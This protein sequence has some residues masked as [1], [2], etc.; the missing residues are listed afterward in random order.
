MKRP[1]RGSG[2]PRSDGA[3]G[4]RGADHQRRA[5]RVDAV[6]ADVRA[7]AVA[8]RREPRLVAVERLV[9]ERRQALRPD[10]DAR[11]AARSSHSFAARS[12]SPVPDALERVAPRTPRSRSWRYSAKPRKRS[13][14]RKTSGRSS[15]SQASFAGQKLGCRNA[16]GSRVHRRRVEPPRRARRPAPTDRVSCQISSGADRPP[17]RVDREQAVPEAADRDRVDP[18]P[19]ADALVDRPRRVDDVVGVELGPPA[20]PVRDLVHRL[21]LLAAHGPAAL[22]ERDRARTDEVPTSRAR[23]R[24]TRPNVPA[25]PRRCT[26][27]ST[28]SAWPSSSPRTCARSLRATCCSTASRSRSS[29]AT[30]S[31]SPGRTAP[32]RR[33][34]SG[35]SPARPRSTAASSRSRRGRG[36]R[37]TTSG[38]RSSER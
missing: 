2:R 21:R 1:G 12:S 3:D 36:S 13:A 23:T 10:A 14:A 31:R 7:G 27:G 32:A 35:S 20:A 24:V 11:P 22:V 33:R 29:A 4:S 37:C 38:R 19:A 17:A 5:A 8:E 6:R 18:L 16:P 25:R 26:G 9:R 15:R 28:L 30:G 34:C